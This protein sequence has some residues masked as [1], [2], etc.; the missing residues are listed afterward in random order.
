MSLSEAQEVLGALA[1]CLLS[2]GDTYHFSSP[3]KCMGAA[4]CQRRRRWRLWRET[5]RKS[6]LLSGTGHLPFR[7]QL[8]GRSLRSEWGGV[9]KSAGK[10]AMQ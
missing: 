1:G 10:E 5:G 8:T 3:R 2:S 7:G 9:L 6:P 4:Y